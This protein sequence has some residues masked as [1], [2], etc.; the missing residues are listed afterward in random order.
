[1][2][3]EIRKMETGDV[4]AVAV[5]HVA[6]FP[7]FFL[8]FLGPRF[9]RELYRA[10]LADEEG[11]A[12][13]ATEAGRLLGFAAGTASAGFYRRAAR[14]RWFRFGAASL[15]AL[16]RKPSIAPRLLRALYAPPSVSARGAVLMSLAVD[17]GAQRRG[18]GMRLT[19]A[20]ADAA[21]RRGV[22][23]I[24]LSTD[25]VGNDPANAFYQAQGF[26]LTG[27]YV[28][29]EGRQM[30]QYVLLINRAVNEDSS[31]V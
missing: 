24:V 29:P 28:T 27:D 6:A 2:N 14:R 25:K 18:V 11:M 13:V 7:R 12:V 30:C 4:D 15:G 9:L 20:F 23:K 5:I 10:I 31:N 3:V 16:W 26:T 1:M 17:P 8:S 19:S 22:S 21:R